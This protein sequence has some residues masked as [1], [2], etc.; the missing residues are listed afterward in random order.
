MKDW[1][2]VRPQYSE[3]KEI[4]QSQ[5]WFKVY[6]IGHDILAIY[7]PYHFQ[8][9]IS[10]LIKGKDKA[11]LWDTGLGIGDMKKCV[12][13][14]WDGEL[15]VCNSHH[16]FDHFLGDWQFENVYA[17]D[18][19]DMIKALTQP[20]PDT[21]TGPNFAEDQFA[22][23]APIKSHTY[24]FHPISYTLIKEGYVF[25]LGG[26]R[27]G[28]VH[29][30]GHAKDAI[31]LD[32]KEEKILFTGDTYYPAPMYCFEPTFDTYVKTM[33]MLAEK[34]SDYLLVTSHNEPLRPGSIFIPIAK[35]FHDIK[36]HKLSKVAEFGE[37]EMFKTEDFALIKIKD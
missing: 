33:D 5:P 4:E 10:Y 34:Y 29:T 9:V 19:P 21:Y 25:D 27:F 8:E 26:R 28:V 1:E 31:M 13:E 14:L 30:P 22:D 36:E 37:R 20:L 17:F 24:E 7:E 18:H 3:F 6:D 16:H 11:L 2:Q 23:D 35:G 15:L 32:N 12:S